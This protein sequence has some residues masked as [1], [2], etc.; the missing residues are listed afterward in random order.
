VD[1][2]GF[3]A[4]LLAGLL[5]DVLAGALLL[6]VGYRLIDRKFQIEER[7][8]RAREAAATE[9]RN[10]ES[11]LGAVLGELVSNAAQLTT[12]LRRMPKPSE[13]IL[14]PLFDVA[15]WP[16]VS[17]P[18][19]LTTLREK[20]IADVTHVYNRMATANEQNAYLSDLNHG[21][22]SLLVNVTAAGTVSSDPLVQKAYDKF[23]D[24]RDYVRTGVIERLRELKPHLD[25]AIDAVELE[26]GRP[27]EVPAAQR[28][29]EPETPPG[30]IGDEQSLPP[31]PQ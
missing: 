22:T 21:R 20:T 16:L 1:F 3:W 29:F 5:A 23:L 6:Y 9:Q 26:L 12:A 27:G 8:Q 7:E 31:A 19:I 17:S 30:F 11:V 15:L 4:G 24:L 13:A 10:R 25:N 18:A 2:S 14:Y 28:I